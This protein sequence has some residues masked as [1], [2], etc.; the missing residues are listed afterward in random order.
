VTLVDQLTRDEGLRLHPYTDTAG[1]LTIGIG[2]NLTDDG[3]SEPE[4]ELLLSN[5]I[6]VASSRLE[7]AFPWTSGLDDVRRAA[8]INMTFN[9]GVG[10]LAEFK[11]F[12]AAA[13]VGNWTE[14][15]N[16]MLDSAWATEVGPRA[17][18]LA[19]QIE[20]GEFQ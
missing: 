19:I 14:A 6:A 5:D 3:I 20:T 8:L 15:R 7:E 9:M 16:Q 13:Q 1:K 11:L 4:A 12:L 18:R 17:V 2:R 10:G